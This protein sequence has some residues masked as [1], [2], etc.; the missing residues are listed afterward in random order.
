LAKNRRSRKP[1]EKSRQNIHVIVFWQLFKKTKAAHKMKKVKIP[2]TALAVML[3][4]GAALAFN[5]PRPNTHKTFA[6]NQTLQ[7]WVDVTGQTEGVDY[8]CNSSENLCTSQFT[9]DDPIHGQMINPVK[10]TYQNLD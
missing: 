10:G 9:N 6:W 3:G 2:L 4:L 1:V 5:A 7:E 8:N